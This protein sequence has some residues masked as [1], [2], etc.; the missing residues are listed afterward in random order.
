MEAA[1]EIKDGMAQVAQLRLACTHDA[2]LSAAVTEVKRFQ[3]QRFQGAYADLLQSELYREPT[4]F[5]LDELYSEKDYTERDNQFARIAGAIQKLFPQSVVDTAVLLAKLHS[6]SEELDFRMATVWTAA[7]ELDGMDFAERYVYAWRSV[8]RESDRRW[9]LAAVL[10]LGRELDHLTRKPGL[11]MLLK[12][13]RRPAHTAGLG[14]LQAFLE[15]GFD[16]FAA[17]ARTHSQVG[18]FLEM[19]E[20]RESAWFDRLFG[21]STSGCADALR[22]CMQSIRVNVTAPEI[23]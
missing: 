8:G 11:R 19:I 3:S 5:F 1:Q 18:E 7:S 16:T 9:Q 15:A 13:M 17:M 20:Q 14:S 6:V 21:P 10:Q 22:L 2:Q 23:Q 12:M 4:R